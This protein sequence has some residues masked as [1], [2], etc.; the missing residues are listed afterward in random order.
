MI[1]EILQQSQ[2]RAFVAYVLHDQETMK[3]ATMCF[4]ESEFRS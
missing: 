3:D 4:P 1:A 2:A